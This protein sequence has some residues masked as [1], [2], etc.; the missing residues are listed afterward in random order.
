VCF[1][2]RPDAGIDVGRA[3]GTGDVL[4]RAIAPPRERRLDPLQEFVT[5]GRTA[6]LK[7]RRAARLALKPEHVAERV[8]RVPRMQ[9][10]GRAVVS[11]P[12]SVSNTVLSRNAS[13]AD[14]DVALDAL[15]RGVTAG[16]RRVVH[17]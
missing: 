4:K 16:L 5:A 14:F 10:S 15:V 11:V 8:S 9:T 7:A 6:P 1:S 17:P 2:C 3:Q 13:E 12:A